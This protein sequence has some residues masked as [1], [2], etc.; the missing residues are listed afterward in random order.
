MRVTA[1]I[2]TETSAVM[3]DEA[4]AMV[5]LALAPHLDVIRSLPHMRS[6][7]VIRAPLLP[8]TTLR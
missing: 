2:L 7:E 3:S 6:M 8:V 1:T 4:A 5:A